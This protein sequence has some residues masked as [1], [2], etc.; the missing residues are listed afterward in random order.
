MNLL[1]TSYLGGSST[2]SPSSLSS[3]LSSIT[4]VVN[5]AITWTSSFVSFIT[6]NPLVLVFVILAFVGLGV[7]LLKRLVNL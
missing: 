6:G 4:S 2:P 7:G 3:I 5:S 1:L